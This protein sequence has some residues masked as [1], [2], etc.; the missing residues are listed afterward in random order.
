MK[1][2]TEF[3]THKVLGGFCFD[4]NIKTRPGLPG[5]P[6]SSC[7]PAVGRSVWASNEHGGHCRGVVWAN[8]DETTR[9]PVCALC[10]KYCGTPVQGS[11][12]SMCDS[13]KSVPKNSLR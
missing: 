6:K 4:C 13:Y 3:K 9:N 8:G 12:T 1:H 2:E 5:W 11:F 10:G 7:G